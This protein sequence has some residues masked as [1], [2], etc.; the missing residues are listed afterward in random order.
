MSRHTAA[1]VQ[2]AAVVE[3]RL[4]A[5]AKVVLAAAAVQGRLA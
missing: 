5:T 3:I 1:A 4:E 2:A